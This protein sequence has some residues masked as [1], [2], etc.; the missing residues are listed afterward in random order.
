MAVASSLHPCGT[1]LDGA[2]DGLSDLLHDVVSG[3][4][5]LADALG[6][7]ENQ[8]DAA[9]EEHCPDVTFGQGLHLR[10]AGSATAAE[11]ARAGPPGSA[12][13]VALD[14]EKCGRVDAAARKPPDKCLHCSVL[15]R[16]VQALLQALA[17]L[18]ASACNWSA[19]LGLAHHLELAKLVL[20]YVR[21]CAKLDPEGLG[22]LCMALESASLDQHYSPIHGGPFHGSTGN[23][24][25]GVDIDD[26][27]LCKGYVTCGGV[28]SGGQPAM[29]RTLVRRRS[30]SEDVRAKSNSPQPRMRTCLEPAAAHKSTKS[31]PHGHLGGPG[32]E[33]D[34]E[35]GAENARP[36]ARSEAEYEYTDEVFQSQVG[37]RRSSANF[38]FEDAGLDILYQ[39]FG[40]DTDTERND[41][42]W[43][44]SGIAA[45]KTPKR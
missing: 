32:N 39:E 11:A 43:K 7:L 3:R 31:V 19:G 24:S 20:D 44:G 23:H 38:F 36:A 45:G 1:L 37:I 15:L 4:T 17:G 33:P 14:A 35:P 13:L 29:P 16:Q 18:A 41:G 30:R 12:D 22:A 5:S 26:A 21:P 34:A 6:C 8:L 9:Y 25:S 42:A 40:S 2:E 10:S 28:G 27:H